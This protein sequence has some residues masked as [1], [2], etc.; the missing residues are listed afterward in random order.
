MPPGLVLP[1]GD[2]AFIKSKGEDNSRNGAAV[3]E[4]SQ[5]Q[6]HQPSWMFEL[7]EHSTGGFGKGFL[8]SVADVLAFGR[9]VDADA[10]TCATFELEAY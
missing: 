2:R 7:I 4:Q 10:P 3:R 6:Q 1:I 5:D 8:A 9:G